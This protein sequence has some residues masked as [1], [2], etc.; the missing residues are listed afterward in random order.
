ML[1][2]YLQSVIQKYDV[3]FVEENDIIGR[4]KVVSVHS[5]SEAYKISEL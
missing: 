3:L 1:G 5:E 4:C 2:N